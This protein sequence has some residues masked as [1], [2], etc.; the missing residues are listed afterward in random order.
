MPTGTTGRFLF[1]RH[2]ETDYNRRGVRCGGDVDIP[3]TE[4][5]EAQAR[6]AGERIRADHAG[7]DV[8]LAGPLQRTRRTAEIV[9]DILGGC[10]I[11]THAGLIERR[12]GAWNGLDIAATQADLAAGATP[13]GGEAEGDFRARVAAALADIL[14]RGDRLPLLVGSKGVGRVV[15]L[16][17]GGAPNPAMGNAEVVAYGLTLPL[18]GPAGTGSGDQRG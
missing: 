4:R 2:G 12:L 13:P 18:A 7:I 10:P 3:L 17:A 14:G 9:A 8:I 16:L 1:M 6:D 11:V 15:A 5:G